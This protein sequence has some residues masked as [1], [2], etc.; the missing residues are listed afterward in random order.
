MRIPWP[1]ERSWEILEQVIYEIGDGQ[2][3]LMIYLQIRRKAVAD[4]DYALS[5][6]YINLNI[7]FI[8]HLFHL[9]QW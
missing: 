2:V 8:I 9:F 1:S 4:F 5:F 7:N 3:S 6:L